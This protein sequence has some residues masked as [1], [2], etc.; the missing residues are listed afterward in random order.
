M[1]IAMGQMRVTVLYAENDFHQLS[2]RK[3]NAIDTMEEQQTRLR[4]TQH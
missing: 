1:S 3:A 4:L 2:K